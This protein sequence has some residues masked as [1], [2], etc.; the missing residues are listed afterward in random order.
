MW[1]NKKLMA[2][3]YIDTSI[4][5]KA[6]HFAI[7]AHANTERRGK[8]FPYAVHLMEAVEIVATITSDQEILA[9]AALHDTVEDTDVT[10]DQLRREFGDRVAE[11]VEYESDKCANGFSE[12][13]S[14]VDRKK[15]GIERLIN[16]PYDA[17]I[18]AMGDKLSN[19]RAIAR[20]YERIG[21]ELWKIFHSPNGKP[22]HEW[23]YR[24]LAV[25]LFDLAGTPA[26]REFVTLLEKTFGQKDF[27]EPVKIDLSD[28]ERSGEGYNAMSY[29]HKGGH[30]MIKLYAEAV[31]PE[32][33]L[34]ELR[35]AMNVF[36]MGLPTPMPGRFVTD[37]KRYGCEFG[38]IVDKK[39][40]ARAISENPD[41]MERY[42]T[43]F[44]RMCKQLHSTVCN[45]A[46]FPSAADMFSEAV[47]NTTFFSDEE[48]KKV[49][50]FVKN[51]PSAT[52][53]LHGDLHIGN[54][55]SS[56]LGNLWIDL[57]DFGY[58]NPLFDLGMTYWISKCNLE[59]TTKRLYHIDNKMMQKIWE[60]FLRE[61][62]G[63]DNQEELAEYERQIRP[64]AALKMI[65]FGVTKG[66]EELIRENLLG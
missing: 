17:K 52:T 6:M 48:K 24:E 29:N 8:G 46:V 66:H 28:Y 65:Y 33:P 35:T 40:F 49:L 12:R 63:T 39:S 58:G 62:Y 60:I 42:A 59:E 23:R 10:I 15:A 25:A 47:E 64:F 7:D 13:D 34:R 18:V 54:I 3:K 43:E 9:A 36:R 57:G 38:R 21:D 53:C 30:T 51:V 26:Y 41:S 45:P 32:L 20:D 31:S 50:D 27:S 16:A 56:S 2:N 37:G 4:L 19:M 61:Y 5:D 22:D 55:L 11:L 1:T 44:A 14:W